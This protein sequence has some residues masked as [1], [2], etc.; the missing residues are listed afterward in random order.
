MRTGAVA[1]L[2]CLLPAAL[3]TQ[4]RTDSATLT[5]EVKSVLNGELLAGV[6]IALPGLQKFV[7]TDST[8]VFAFTVPPG[9]H[10]MSVKYREHV[11]E[12]YDM[13]MRAGQHTRL[14]I[15]LDVEA[16]HLAPVVV[17]G[18]ANPSDFGIAGFYERKRFGFGRFVTGEQIGRDRSQSLADYM[19]R[20]GFQYGCARMRCGLVRNTAGGPCL[21]PVMVDGVP[22]MGQDVRT[23]QTHE[24]GGIEIYRSQTDVPV[25]FQMA[26]SVD[27][28]TARGCGAVIVWTKVWELGRADSTGN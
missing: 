15:L 11:N 3:A 6:L 17:D 19:S 10:H 27:P 12:D 1:L 24:L 5:G 14:E 25:S 13:I 4:V 18:R 20:F 23:L 9:T 2:V 21:V 26:L 8:G 16:V 28:T 22:E 7:V